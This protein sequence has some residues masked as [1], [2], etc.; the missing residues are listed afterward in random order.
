[1]IWRVCCTIF[2]R[3]FV[4]FDTEGFFLGKIDSVHIDEENFDLEAEISGEE[5]GERKLEIDVKAVTYN[6][7]FVKLEKDSWVAQVV[8]D[9]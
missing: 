9:V 2:R 8:V 1:M 6:E 3:T 7:M 5:I 4:L